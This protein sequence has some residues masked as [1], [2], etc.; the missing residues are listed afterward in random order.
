MCGCFTQSFTWAELAALYGL[1]QPARNLQPRYGIAPAAMI[2]A[3][4]LGREGLELVAMRC[5]LIP[6]WRKKTAKKV[7]SMFKMELVLSVG[8]PSQNRSSLRD[9]SSFFSDM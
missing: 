1:T 2:E 9:L 6:S 4:R 5:G 7:P 3:A 8:C